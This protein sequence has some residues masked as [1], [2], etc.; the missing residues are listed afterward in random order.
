M[1]EEVRCLLSLQ[2]LDR[3]LIALAQ[4]LEKLPQEEARARAKL[5]DD[6]KAVAD[7]KDTV[8]KGEIELKKLELDAETRKTTI[9]RLK[10]QQF[11]TRKNEEYQALAHEVE[12]Y[13]KEVDELET[14]ELE[15]M[16]RID[17]ARETLKQAQDGLANTQKRVDE[18][19]SSIRQ[20]HDIK[21]AEQDELQAQR[22][23]L[24][25]EIP[26]SALPLYDRLMKSKN[27][28]AIAEMKE[29][30]CEGCHMKLIPSTVASV[31]NGKELTRCEDCGRILY[32]SE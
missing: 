32:V 12:R 29:G 22:D 24:A 30:K 11:E 27:G 16:E 25:A 28:L 19:L 21:K 5:A 9:G 15:I 18:D 17:Q 10:T 8:N 2:N 4:D 3:R 13:E 6:E 14:Q 31:Q 7:A 23:T 20:R 26:E 1:L